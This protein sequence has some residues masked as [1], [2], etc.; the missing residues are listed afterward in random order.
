MSDT[1]DTIEVTL[2]VSGKL[3]VL[4]NYTKRSDEVAYN[5]VL[6][7]NV[8]VG[9]D[10]SDF[11]MPLQNSLDAK[12]VYVRRLTISIGGSEEDIDSEIENL[13]VQDYDE[14]AKAV[15]AIVDANS[16]KAKAASKPTTQK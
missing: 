1:V 4:R 9:A 3:V 11:T 5:S 13:R 8:E 7:K 14:L 15:D 6:Y 10:Q 12:D 16:P 2:P